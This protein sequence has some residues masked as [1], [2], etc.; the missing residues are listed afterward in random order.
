MRRARKKGKKIAAYELG[1]GS[2]M[3]L[4]LMREGK[5]KSDD[6]K[7]FSL[8]SFEGVEEATAGDFFKVSYFDGEKF[9]YPNS[10]SFFLLNHKHLGDDYYEQNSK[11]ISVWFKGDSLEEPEIKFLFQTGKLTLNPEDL[12]H[13]FEAFLW[14]AKLSAASDAVLIFYEVERD[15]DLIQDIDF[16]LVNRKIFDQDYLLLQ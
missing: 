10:R 9:P 4:E 1:A 6:G 15:G 8:S 3:E 13:Y 5:I 2:S 11:P 16:A 7:K 14:G 12:A